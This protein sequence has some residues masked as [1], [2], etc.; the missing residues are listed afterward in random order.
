MF[1]TTPIIRG[2]KGRAI[3]GVAKTSDC[4]KNYVSHQCQLAKKREIEK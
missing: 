1:T 3:L 2:T 4:D